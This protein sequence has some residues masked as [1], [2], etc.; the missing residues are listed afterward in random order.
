M[1]K[2]TFET[3]GDRKFEGQIIIIATCKAV[4]LRQAK[5]FLIGRNDSLTGYCQ[6]EKLSPLAT[7]VY[8][9]PGEY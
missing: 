2:Y 6:S 3:S 8:Y 7:V 4:A 5:K 9:S 1:R